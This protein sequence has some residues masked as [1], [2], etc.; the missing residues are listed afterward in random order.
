LAAY[1]ESGDTGD[2]EITE[3]SEVAE[4]AEV[5]EVTGDYELVD[6]IF[7]VFGAL[8]YPQGYCKMG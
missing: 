6:N 5:A 7:F 1:G 8:W 3:V 2:Y 4:V